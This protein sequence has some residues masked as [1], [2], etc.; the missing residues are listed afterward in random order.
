MGGI[1]AVIKNSI[2]ELR[3][4]AQVELNKQSA[5]GKVADIEF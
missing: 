5:D 4:A 3:L 1:K 2:T